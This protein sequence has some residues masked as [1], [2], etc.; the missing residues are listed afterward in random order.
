MTSKL[1]EKILNLKKKKL[2]IG[3]VHGVFDVFI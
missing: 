2:K 3:L 1:R